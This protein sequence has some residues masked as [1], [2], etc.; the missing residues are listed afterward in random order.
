MSPGASHDETPMQVPP[1]QFV[2][3]QSVASVQESPSVLQVEPLPPGGSGA[4]FDPKPQMPE[5][6]CVSLAQD[7][8]SWMHTVEEQVAP[9]LPAFGQLREQHCASDPQASPG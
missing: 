3:Q 5:Q 2:E 6:H 7:W 9:G 8:F 4:H 1:W